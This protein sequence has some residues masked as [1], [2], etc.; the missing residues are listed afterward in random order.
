MLK[1]RLVFRGAR[2]FSG[3]VI[4]KVNCAS[5]SIK[6]QDQDSSIA[7]YYTKPKKLPDSRSKPDIHDLKYLLFSQDIQ[8]SKQAALHDRD[9]ITTTDI[10]ETKDELSSRIIC[11]RCS[12]ALHQN[13]YEFKEFPESALDEVLNYIPKNSNVMHIVPFVEFPLHMNPNI[14]KSHDLDATL[15]LTKSDQ[16]FKDKTSVSKK[17][18]I[19]M[20]QFLKYNL[21][22]DSNKTFA[23]SA[24]K[25]WN[26]SMLY[27]SLR[28]YTYLLGNPNVGKS[29]LIN[30]L[31]QRY[32]GYKIKVNPTGQINSPS[33]EVMQEALNKPRN[34][35]RTQ[36]AGV[37]H[38]P[39]LTRS[40]QAY[41]A[42]GKIIFDLPG[43]SMPTSG[44]R[45]EELFDKD[46]LQRIRKTN[47]FNRKQV[48]KKNYESMCGTSQGACYTVGGLFYLVPP[49]GSIN[50]IVKYIPGPSTKFKHIEKGIEVFSSC[51]S[52]SG[53]HALSQCCG[54]KSPLC[55]KEQYARYAIPPFV[56][57][58][59]IVLKNLGYILL[60]TTGKYDFKGLHEIWVPRGIDVCI[61][62]PLEKLI[63]TGYERY[64][65]TDGKESSCP[66]DRPIISSLYEV[67]KDETDVLNKVKRLYLDR[68]K[69][70][71]SA[72]RFAD[73]D[74]YDLVKQEPEEKSNPYWYY[75]W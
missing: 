40:I 3:S 44:L 1:L 65:E 23:I 20:K 14:L 53:T 66:R 52:S 21:R 37:S 57:S 69:N 4:T 63:E 62:E 28:N 13:R 16:L 45:L 49:E 34:F 2:Q 72:R 48:K 25:N 33:K 11:K 31:L 55:D 5:C 41:Q 73:D 38:I 12:D 9:H 70:D 17:V 71:L 58:I 74:P 75:Q 32:L 35:F 46:W 50:Q 54:I 68:T 43:Y 8:L 7:G 42:S 22:I 67:A 6:L 60:R 59:E 15:L 64:M 61:R 30:S 51:V 19:F 36:A 29:T 26:I 27:N 10:E 24:L 18:P 39:N 47:L 56:G